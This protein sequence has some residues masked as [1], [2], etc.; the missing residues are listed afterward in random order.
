MNPGFQAYFFV[1]KC[2]R[3][4]NTKQHVQGQDKEGVLQPGF[5]RQKNMHSRRERLEF[6]LELVLSAAWGD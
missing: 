1:E 4:D 2:N 6:S 5:T 3:R